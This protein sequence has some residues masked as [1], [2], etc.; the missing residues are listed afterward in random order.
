MGL[1]S[2]IDRNLLLP[3]GERL[4]N[5]N[6][7]GEYKESLALEWLSKEELYQYQCKKLQRLIQHCYQN[8]PYYTQLFDAIGIKPENIRCREDLTCLPVLTKDLIR[9]NYDDLISKDLHKRK[10]LQASTGGSTGVPMKFL[11]DINT[12]NRSRA[13][14]FTMWHNAGYE[15]GEKMFT[16]AGNSLVNKTSTASRGITSKSIYDIV[17]MRNNKQFC[18]NPAIDPLEFHYKS[19]IKYKP[20]AIRG[21]ASSLYFFARYIEKNHLPICP[22]KAIFTTGDMLYP[23]YRHKIQQVFKVPV[24]DAYGASDGGVLAFECPLHEGLHLSEE[25][26]VVEITD[27]SGNVLPDGEVGHIITTD[28]NNYVFP[29]LRYKVGDMGYIKKESCSCG[30]SSRL[31]GEVIGRA[32]K[33]IYNKQG[34]SFSCVVMDNMMFKDIDFHN[35]ENQKLYERMQQFQIRQDEKGDIKILIIPVNS[36]ESIH[37]FDYVLDNFKKHF[38]D[39]IVEL[40]FV[41]EIP[42]MSSGKEDICVSEYHKR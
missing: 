42:T 8:V 33:A 39:S 25:N 11:E 34:R 13:A 31:I 26:C 9:D 5:R 19:M 4:L 20:K 28:L 36:Q 17:I 7:T 15:I 32:S 18:T 14:S 37:T 24:F 6:L 23:K 38:P 35:S 41:S 27:N 21:Y 12:W 3:L 29:F 30:R 10:Y 16:L 1:Y 2:W 22:I 40:K